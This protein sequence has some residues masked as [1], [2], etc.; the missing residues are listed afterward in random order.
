MRIENN[1]LVLEEKDCGC[2]KDDRTPPGT[3]V[4][5]FGYKKCTK[6]K[7]TGMRGS[8]RCR[9]C[10]A[11]D[12]YFSATNPRKAG[13]VPDYSVV[14]EIQPCDACHGKLVVLENRT[15]NLSL[16]IIRAIPMRVE[17]MPNRE[18]TF[19][20]S[21]LGFGTVYS[22]VDY[23]RHKDLSDEEII[24]EVK[25]SPNKQACNYVL[26]DLLCDEIVI[27]SSNQGFSA[28]PK[29]AE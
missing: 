29:W 19:N 4:R 6:C 5:R 15:D 11:R 24:A 13:Y 3:R 10:N 26:R 8:G 20:E 25:A 2:I 12:G 9:E 22:V 28:W 18:I 17:R 16:D 7:G 1:V 23:G 21:Y 27:V 14:E